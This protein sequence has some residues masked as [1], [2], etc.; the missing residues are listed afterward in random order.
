MAYL[1]GKS[2]PGVYQ[3]IINQ[4][5]FHHVYIEPFLGEGAI[6][7]YKLPAA[8]NLGIDKDPTVINHAKLWADNHIIGCHLV[9][10]DGIDYLANL[11]NSVFANLAEDLGW[12]IFIY[13]DPPYLPDT[14]RSKYTRYPYDMTIDQ[15]RQL[16]DI[17]RSL[18]CYI[19]ISGYYSDL[20]NDV[21]KDWRRISYT[22]KTR[23]NT[24]AQE[25]LWMNY[26]VPDRLHDYRYLG[27]NFRE[28]ERIKRMQKRWHKRLS[29]LDQLERYAML[30]LLSDM[31]KSYQTKDDLYE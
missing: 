30:S 12:I 19:A 15:H 6:M 23:G 13:A 18:D 4:I 8:H 20:Y 5:P 22:T 2:S 28:R 31:N 25:Y 1:G 16:L 29:K 27:D 21:L 14:R 10:D 9:V 3:K 17:L 26:P 11:P 24:A 7:R